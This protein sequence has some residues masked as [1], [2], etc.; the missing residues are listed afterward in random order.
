MRPVAQTCTCSDEF[1]EHHFAHAPDC[2]IRLALEDAFRTGWAIARK[3]E[4]SQWDADHMMPI[5][6]SSV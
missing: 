2:P 6:P 4:G 1:R 5:W 3:L